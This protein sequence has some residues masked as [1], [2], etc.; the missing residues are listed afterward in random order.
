MKRTFQEVHSIGSLHRLGT[1]M[2][3]PCMNPEERDMGSLPAY[4]QYCQK[5]CV[6]NAVL[7][8]SFF[9]ASCVGGGDMFGG[10]SISP[11]CHH[12]PGICA[13]FSC[14]RGVTP[15]CAGDCSS[16]PLIASAYVACNLGLNISLLALLRQAGKKILSVILRSSCCSA[17]RH[18]VQELQICAIFPP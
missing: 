16:A 10:S 5:V 7:R 11:G 13:G 9:K 3:L 14:L 17:L 1:V 12:F 15:D 18:Q 6:S 8:L 2:D 4:P